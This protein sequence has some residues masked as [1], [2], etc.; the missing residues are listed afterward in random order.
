VAYPEGEGPV[1][2]D[3]GTP[4][5]FHQL[6]QSVPEILFIIP[7]GKID[8]GHRIYPEGAAFREHQVPRKRA[9]RGAAIRDA[10]HGR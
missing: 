6:D 10:L 3:V 4:P 5:A 1:L 9:H 2:A 7:R 8:Q